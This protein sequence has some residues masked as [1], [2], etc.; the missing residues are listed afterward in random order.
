MSL[1]VSRLLCFA[2]VCAL[3]LLALTGPV[4]AKKPPWAG[5]HPSAVGAP[6]MNLGMAVNALLLLAGAVLLL[7][8]NYRHRQKSHSLLES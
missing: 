1:R 2:S 4:W 8:E 3:C 7:L 5:P 6:E